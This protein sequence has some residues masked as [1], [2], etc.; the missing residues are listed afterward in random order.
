MKGW[1]SKDIPWDRFDAS[2]VDPETVRIVKAAAMV[3]RNAHQYA[4]YLANVFRDD[5][6]FCQVTRDW[7]AE[8]IQHGEVLRRWAE[9]ADPTFDFPAAFQTFTTGYAISTDVDQSIRGSRA[10]ELLA[11]CI[12]ETGTSSYYTAIKDATRE[13]VLREICRLIAADELRH[14]KLFYTHLK[15]YLERDRIGTWERIKV[16]A[17][18]M[19][20]ADDDELAYAYYAANAADKPYDRT[21]YNAAYIRGAYAF[22]QP[23]HIHRGMAMIFKVVGLDPQGRLH[24]WAS[25]LVWWLM[26]SR[27]RRL[28]RVSVA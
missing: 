11:R 17:G 21:T 20:E 7:A 23:H 6:D 28:N 15:T 10:G 13:P 12:V 5:P 19:T 2:K 8:E 4:E 26:G 18:R 22:Y 25:K 9:M 1:T 3:E 24:R 14:Y 16:A 27:L